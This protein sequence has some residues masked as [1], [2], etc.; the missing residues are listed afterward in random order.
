[1]HQNGWFGRYEAV[2][3][4]AATKLAVQ[5]KQRSGCAIN[6]ASSEEFYKILFCFARFAAPARFK[7]VASKIWRRIEEFACARLARQRR[8][9][10]I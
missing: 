1:M 8:N 6:S 2:V 5:N 3:K 4:L 7:S 9:F 10:K